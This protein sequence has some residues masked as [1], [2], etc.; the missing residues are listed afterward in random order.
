MAIKTFSLTLNAEG[1][2]ILSSIIKNKIY[3]TAI[4]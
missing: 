2:N 4:K 1:T 3:T